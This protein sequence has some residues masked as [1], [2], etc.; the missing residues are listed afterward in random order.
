M[1]A[2]IA[3]TRAQQVA[4]GELRITNVAADD[5]KTKGEEVQFWS[6]RFLTK[7]LVAN[8]A[9]FAAVLPFIVKTDSTVIRQEDALNALACFGL[10]LALA[11]ALCLATAC[12]CFAL[13]NYVS[14]H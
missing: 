2:Q 13:L 9:G 3:A 7:F 4:K 8:A 1:V 14:D 12:R 6:R 10:A 5:A 11:L